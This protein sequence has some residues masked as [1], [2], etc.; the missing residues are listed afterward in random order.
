[1]PNYEYQ[2]RHCGEVVTVKHG[3]QEP[4][5]TTT[6]PACDSTSFLKLPSAPAV[7][8]KGSGWTPKGS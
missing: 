4:L 5:P 3:I 7:I 1:M 8:F 6:C 2:C